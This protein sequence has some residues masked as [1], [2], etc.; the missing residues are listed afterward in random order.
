MDYRLPTALDDAI[1]RIEHTFFPALAEAETFGADTQMVAL[2]FRLC[3][4][5]HV[6]HWRQSRRKY[7]IREGSVSHLTIPVEVATV[8]QDVVKNYS[9]ETEATKYFDFFKEATPPLKLLHGGGEALGADHAKSR[10]R[11]TLVR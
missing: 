4:N 11:L 10:A 6:W 8:I 9:T 2:G 5:G 3:R 1:S 7:D